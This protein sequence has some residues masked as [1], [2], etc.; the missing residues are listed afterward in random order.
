MRCS[1]IDWKI[2]LA[3]LLFPYRDDEGMWN[4]RKKKKKK[5][6]EK[7][8]VDTFHLLITRPIIRFKRIWIEQHGSRL[9]ATSTCNILQVPSPNSS[10]TIRSL[11]KFY[12]TIE[13]VQRSRGN[14]WSW[15]DRGSN[16]LVKLESRQPRTTLGN[17]ETKHLSWIRHGILIRFLM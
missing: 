10:C 14:A 16:D 3:R 17:R 5:R 8:N 6:K 12:D 1:V 7:K 9:Y 15:H 11:K 13:R 4:E 2:Y